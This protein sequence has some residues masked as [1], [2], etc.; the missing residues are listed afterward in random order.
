MG[1]SIW[2]NSGGPAV[3]LPVDGYSFGDGRARFDSLVVDWGD[4]PCDNEVID[5]V[6][7][8]YAVSPDLRSANPEIDPVVAGLNMI[9]TF[10]DRDRDATTPTMMW[11]SRS[12][13]TTCTERPTPATRG[14]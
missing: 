7:L 1:S 11:R 12:R 13:S 8:G 5:G 3:Y 10:Y 6:A 9:V 2:S 4:L 14:S